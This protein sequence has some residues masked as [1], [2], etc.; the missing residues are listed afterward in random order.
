MSNS[1]YSQTLQH[2]TDAKLEEL[3]NKRQIF[4]KRKESALETAKSS[5]SP[6]DKV[7]AL[8]DG[9]KTCFNISVKDGRVVHSSSDQGQLEV[10][11]SNLD[12]FLKQ[13]E[14]DPA[15]SQ[16]TVER[17]HQSLLSHLDIQTLKYEYA[18]LFAQ[19][20][21]EWLSVKKNRSSG[22]PAAS[23]DDYEQL[24]TAAKL[25][26]RK[27]WED[28]VFTPA[29]QDGETVK[30]FLNDLFS[31]IGQSEPV[32]VTDKERNVEKT[33][34]LLRDRVAAFASSFTR[35]SFDVSILNWVINGLLHSD[36]VTDKQRAVLRDF[37]NDKTVLTE[38]ADVLNMRMAGLHAWTWGPSVAVE[39][40]RQ[41]NGTYQIYMHEDL[42]Q[43]IFLQYIGVKWSV[44]FKSAL[45]DFRKTT[46]YW[47]SLRSTVPVID[48]KRR[49]FFLEKR[50]DKPSLQIIKEAIHRRA[51]F[52]SQL[53][54]NEYQIRKQEEG[55]EEAN[56]APSQGPAHRSLQKKRSMKAA[57][58]VDVEAAMEDQFEEEEE[59]DED[60]GFG[61]FDGDDGNFDPDLTYDD[62]RAGSVK[63]PANQM[64]AKQ[65]LLLLL[66]ADT[67]INKRLHGEITCF[68]A[69]YESLYP[70]LPHPTILAVLQFLGVS[71]KWL[72]FFEKFLTAPLRFTDEPDTEPRT[73]QRGTP[74][75]H[76][77]SEVFGEVT[78]FC[79]DFMINKECN[80]EI[81]WRVNDDMWFWSHEQQTC[82]AAWQAIQRFNKTMGIS[83]SADK[84]GGAHIKAQPA[85][86]STLHSSLPSG[87][88]RWGMLYLNS[89]TGRFEIDQEMVD[90]HIKEMQRQLD[91]KQGSVFGWIQ[92][93]NSYAS[94]FFTYN[95]GKPANC[96]GQ[97]H[98]DMMLRTH[99]RIQREVFSLGP[100]GGK[101]ESSVITY[102]RDTIRSRFGTENIPDGYF[103][104]PIDLGGLELSSPFIN[105]VSLHDS[106]VADPNTLLDEFLEA[107]QSA[108]ASLKRR[109]SNTDKDRLATK[110]SFRP[111]DMDTFMSFE[112]YT[113]HRELLD[114]GF[115]KQLV[116]IYDQLLKRPKPEDIEQ[117]VSGPVTLGLSQ[118]QSQTN[119]SG[120]KSPWRHMSSYWKWIAQLY[121]PELVER[122][123][124]F[125]VVD[126]GL[127]PIGLVSQ[128]R[129]GRVNWAEK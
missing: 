129:S 23:N 97:A 112:E 60:M 33:L 45:Q 37:R 127:L 121:G 26:S 42:I 71:E 93:W 76:V 110:Q 96:F 109:Y 57:S 65:N 15:I 89:E 20:T 59:S 36:L 124:G 1:E 30:A 35:A 17:W 105:L 99:E 16:D 50:G 90:D 54:D 70:S 43:A 85:Q 115:A 41:M 64:Q 9:V 119:L 22:A 53:L 2:I 13:A 56:Y 67:I 49:D 44:F 19:L 29:G 24:A 63:T 4:L 128:F 101:G 86:K 74:G 32:E 104:L 82:V 55:E 39:Q 83:V 108:Y 100:D 21:M 48:K 18:T 46:G 125:N 98:V 116:S 91:D 94:T 38:L 12:R 114:Y 58:F 122:F 51:Y 47:K 123:G 34:R 27:E 69:Q 84:S 88:I 66:S 80:G 7:R 103:F 92:A 87:K 117:D 78:L 10:A 111:D 62:H 72:T 28:F 68:R 25:E 3:S 75:S 52:V 11:L 61:L 120:I 106:V 107:E 126:P 6:V 81:L 102:L 5:D 73:R 8:G 95:F 77:L 79:L 40:R 14:Y 113:R 31:G 118:L